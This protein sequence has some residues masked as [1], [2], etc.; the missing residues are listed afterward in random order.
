MRKRRVRVLQ[1]LLVAAVVDR[2]TTSVATASTWVHITR[3][4]WAIVPVVLAIPELRG[5]WREMV[6]IYHHA[7]VC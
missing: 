7:V 2:I 5:P 4:R 1:Q 3:L 6:V